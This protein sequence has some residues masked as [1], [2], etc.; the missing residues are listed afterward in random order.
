MS[1]Q[2][3]DKSAADIEK[4]N[5]QQRSAKVREHVLSELGEPRDLRRLQIRWL[6]ED[7]YRVNVIVGTDLV[8]AKV[9]HSYFVVADSDGKVL[10]VAPA[11]TRTYGPQADA[12]FT[13]RMGE[14]AKN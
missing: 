5:E 1:T 14:R 10:T 8:T 3:R 2:P 4:C 7:H 11:I 12:K 9:A 13:L 6:W